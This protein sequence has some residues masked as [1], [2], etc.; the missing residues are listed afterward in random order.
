MV[1]RGYPRLVH[2]AAPC[3]YERYLPHAGTLVP[4][5]AFPEHLQGL[6]NVMSL[7]GVGRIHGV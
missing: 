6:P 2:V 5:R 7:E 3:G 1:M 4:Q